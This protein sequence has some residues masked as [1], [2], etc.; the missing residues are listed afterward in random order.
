MKTENVLRIGQLATTLETQELLKPDLVAEL[1]AIFIAE[2][3]ENPWAK[4]VED[5]SDSHLDCLSDNYIGNGD[6]FANFHTFWL[7]FL[8]EEPEPDEMAKLLQQVKEW[9][10]VWDEVTE[11]A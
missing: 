6:N 5:M 7:N 3:G 9:G 1:K 4:P 8:S 2:T 11:P 10:Y